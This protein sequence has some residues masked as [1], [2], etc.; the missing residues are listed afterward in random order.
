M[1]DNQFGNIKWDKY[2][3]WRG[4]ITL[5]NGKTAKVELDVD[6]TEKEAALNTLKFL[7]EGETQIRHKIALLL[8]R[9]CKEWIEDYV[10]TPE[11]LALR[12]D[13]SDIMIGEGSDGK[14]YYYAN[15]DDGMFTDHAVCVWFDANGEINDEVELSG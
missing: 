11:Q 1:E 5:A 7:I 15:G 6:E 13:L 3:P 10:T 4:I 14:L 12:I 8:F 2:K 9:D